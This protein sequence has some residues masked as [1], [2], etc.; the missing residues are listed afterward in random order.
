MNSL[1]WEDARV[2]AFNRLYWEQTGWDR[3][4]FDFN[5]LASRLDEEVPPSL[6]TDESV[7]RY[8]RNADVQTRYP[9]DWPTC[10]LVFTRRDNRRKHVLE[11]H[12][13]EKRTA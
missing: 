8:G 12:M 11:M 4:G 7:F 9:C 6:L 3:E 13:L 10:H 5:A 1:E 2:Q